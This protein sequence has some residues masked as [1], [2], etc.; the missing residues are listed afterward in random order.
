M[1]YEAGLRMEIECTIEA[2]PEGDMTLDELI[3]YFKATGTDVLKVDRRRNLLLI[4]RD[5]GI[6]AWQWVRGW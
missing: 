6:G 1:T 5:K 4:G 3:A 2:K